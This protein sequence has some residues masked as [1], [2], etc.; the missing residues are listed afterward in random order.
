MQDLMTYVTQLSAP[1]MVGVPGVL[2]YLG[3]F[4]AVQAEI[5]SGDSIAYSAANVIAA[6]CV[7]LSLTVEFNLASLL[8]QISFITIGLVGIARRLWQRNRRIPAVV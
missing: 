1:Q 2:V 6:S 4:A 8:I 7:L 5:L 3:S